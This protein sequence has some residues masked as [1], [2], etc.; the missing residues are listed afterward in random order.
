MKEGRPTTSIKRQEGTNIPVGDIDDHQRRNKPER[1]QRIWIK[2]LV[3]LRVESTEKILPKDGFFLK[4][5]DSCEETQK[6]GGIGD[7]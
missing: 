5:F 2:K 4:A 7:D 6:G 3:P 1:K